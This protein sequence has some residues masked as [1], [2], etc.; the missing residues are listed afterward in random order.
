MNTPRELRYAKTHEWVRIEGDL[1]RV[2][3][4]DYAQEQLGDIVFVELPVVG[5][6]YEREEEIA[7][8]ESVKAAS[9]IYSPVN[10]EVIEVNGE[11]EKQPELVNKEPYQAFLFVL[12]ISE[13][14]QLEELLDADAYEAVVE[15]D[16]AKH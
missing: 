16:R 15:Q 5:D 9:P 10:G 1:A 2:G 6:S 8:V 3:I 13:A 12:R 7:T 4:T 11:L 14:E